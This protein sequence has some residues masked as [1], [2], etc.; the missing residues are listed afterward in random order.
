MPGEGDSDFGLDSTLGLDADPGPMGTR[1]ESELEEWGL[2]TIGIAAH[3]RSGL[4]ARDSR[5]G[6]SGALFDYPGGGNW[7]TNRNFVRPSQGSLSS[8][9]TII[10][11]HA[12]DPH[13]RLSDSDPDVIWARN[14]SGSDFNSHFCDAG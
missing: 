13:F 3:S 11:S 1:F 12:D 6:V 4:L 10:R 5:D 8:G 9:A 2:R 14:G 7:N